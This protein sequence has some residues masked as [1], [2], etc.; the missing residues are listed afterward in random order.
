MSPDCQHHPDF[1]IGSLVP[2]VELQYRCVDLSNSLLAF[3]CFSP[4][5]DT[6]YGALTDSK[7]N[8][9]SRWHFLATE[10]QCSSC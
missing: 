5:G 9:N 10:P 1:W 8:L 6:E 4:L 7:P 3:H 2:W